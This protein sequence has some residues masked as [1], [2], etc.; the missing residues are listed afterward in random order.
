MESLPLFRLQPALDFGAL[1]GAVV[2]HDQVHL[3]IGGKI[4]FQMV[5]EADKLAA[6]TLV[7]AGNFPM[8]SGCL[9]PE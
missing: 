7:L 9:T 3:L 1:V 6:A 4:F 2:I 8:S 5:Q